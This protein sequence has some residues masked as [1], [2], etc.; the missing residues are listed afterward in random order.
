MRRRAPC[1]SVRLSPVGEG[2][3]PMPIIN[4]RSDE[5]GDGGDPMARV[6]QPVCGRAAQR[7]RQVIE[8]RIALLGAGERPLQEGHRHQAEQTHGQPVVECLHCTG[9]RKSKRF[10]KPMLRGGGLIAVALLAGC[11]RP[12]PAGQVIADVGGTDVTRRE[13]SEQRQALGADA[14]DKAALDQLV[15]RKI[16]AE[17]AEGRGLER[18]GDYHFALRAARE[19]LLVD[20][21]RRDIVRALP[22]VGAEEVAAQLSR[23]PWRYGARFRLDIQPL[24]ATGGQ[25]A[26]AIDSAALPEGPSTTISAARPGQ[27]IDLEGRKW[28]VLDRVATGGDREAL[29]QAARVDLLAARTDEELRQI[30]VN[31]RQSGK[32]RYQMGFG[33]ARQK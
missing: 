22:P 6:A 11:D 4:G 2:L 26:V 15:A 19:Q 5:Q 14:D 16:L 17:E 12:L 7:W 21:L 3:D 18:D 32:I 28:V 33:P 20:A 23:Q 9:M 29:E 8:H 13:L 27:V 31:Y 1:S 24:G 30:V 10:G 25:G